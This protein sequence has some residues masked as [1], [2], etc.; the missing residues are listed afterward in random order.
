MTTGQSFFRTAS[1]WPFQSRR[2]LRDPLAI[3]TTQASKWKARRRARGTG[4]RR[5]Q[6]LQ[7]RFPDV[8]GTH[9]QAQ[10]GKLGGDSHK[11]SH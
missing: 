2:S 1:E 11:I 3:V 7:E 8:F 4:V 10:T 6:M 5:A 9:V